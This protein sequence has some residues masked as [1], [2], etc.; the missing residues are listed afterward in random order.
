MGKRCNLI[1]TVACIVATLAA[2]GCGL[3]DDPLA[4]GDVDIC[5]AGP[6]G[7]IDP[8][9]PG[10][11]NESLDGTV[12][13]DSAD[14][15]TTDLNCNLSRVL[16]VDVDG[17]TWRVGYRAID[18]GGGDITPEVGFAD[19][20]AIHLTLVRDRGWGEY[21]AFAAQ[22]Q[23]GPLLAMNDG[24]GV[25]LP[26]GAVEELSVSEDGEDGQSEDGNC[27][28]QVG[29]ELVFRANTTT[30]LA[31]GESGSVEIGSG[32]IQVMNVATWS[33]AKNQQVNCTDI[34]GPSAWM[35]WR[36]AK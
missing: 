15:D 21:Y 4:D 30:S 9:K 17:Q 1:L 14:G 35:A 7:A 20:Q 36:T 32:P 28:K 3:L 10:Q 16:S 29:H 18:H 6:D 5:F 19:G 23:D 26:D 22:V 12:V 8:A 27:G 13:S 25:E 33:F 24:M 2:S 34:W 11:L 31:N